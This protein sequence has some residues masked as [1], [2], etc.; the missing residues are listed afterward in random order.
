MSKMALYEPFGYLQCKLCTK[1]GPEV[2]LVIWLL[3]VKLPI[4]LLRVKLPIWLSATKCRE[5][6]RPW[7]VQVKCDTLL[8]SSQSLGSLNRD[9]FGTP[10]WE[11]W[12][13]VP[14]GCKCYEQTQRILYGGRWWLPSSPGH[15]ESCES[16]VA[17]AC[18]NTKSATECELTNFLVRLSN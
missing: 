4:W 11:S 16:R 9:S 7:C 13:K 15:G 18:P 6:T 14:F 1:E 8:K 5:S 2:K 12:E 10:P 17:R 3:R